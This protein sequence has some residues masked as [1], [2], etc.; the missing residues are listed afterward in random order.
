MSK[1]L[2]K[3]TGIGAAIVAVIVIGA[4]I[5]STTV[6]RG[7]S[8]AEAKE[9]AQKYVPSTAKFVTSEEEDNKFE[10]MFHDDQNREGF[11]VEIAKDTKKVKKVESQLDNDLG[12][13]TVKLT[14]KEVKKIIEKEF[15]GV[16]SV[17]ITLN[18]DNGLYEYE[19]NFK[20]KEFY[21][22]ADV[23]PVN[24]KILDSTVKYGTAVTIPD[25]GNQ[26][27]DKNTSKSAGEFITYE[28]AKAAVIKFAG[29]GFVKDIELD[30]ENKMYF[31]EIELI[32]DNMEED[33]YVDAKTGEV[34]LESKHES[35]F[36]YDDHD[37][38]GSYVH[39]NDSHN[40]NHSSGQSGQTTAQKQGTSGANTSSKGDKDTTSSAGSN[41]ISEEKAKA[42]VL[43]KAPGATFVEF[44][45]ERDD[46]IYVYEGEVR[47]S[48]Y[49]Y[50]FELNASTGVIIDWDKER[51]DYD[52]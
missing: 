14:E 47:D 50:E 15:K 21:G 41:L 8:L 35:Y 38:D 36:D 22:D 29:G 24:G 46:G 18:Q 45:L 42:I 6:S 39:E 27:G 11:E 4:M 26:K 16:S 28:E 12:G 2:N 7:M 32:R 23:H 30:R 49:E 34:M 48:K 3:K 13:E 31:Y 51:I 25:S 10:V 43:A 40:G 5:V 52:D 44:K 19:A 1:M 20:A 9:I 17:N 37:G 33:Y